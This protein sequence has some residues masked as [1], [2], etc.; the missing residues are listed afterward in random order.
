MVGGIH[1]YGGFHITSR[2]AARV[3]EAVNEITA[4]DVDAEL[5]HV[6]DGTC[7]LCRS[8]E[9]GDDASQ[10]GGAGRRWTA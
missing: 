8:Q 6:D 9:A 4:R 5:S 2:L 7:G 10:P 3:L 1:V